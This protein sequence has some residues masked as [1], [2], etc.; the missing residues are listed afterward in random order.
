MQAHLLQ[1]RDVPAGQLTLWFAN[2]STQ[3]AVV[4]APLDE[5]PL[6]A[7]QSAH[8]DTIPTAN[9]DGSDPA[10]WIGLSCL[11]EGATR[12]SISETLARYVDRHEIFDEFPGIAVI[13]KPYAGDDLVEALGRAVA[14]R[15]AAG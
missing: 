15:R 8:M 11:L 1:P 4:S 12:S 2:K 6:T 5:R 3:R 9:P 10:P 14:R 7:D 13:G